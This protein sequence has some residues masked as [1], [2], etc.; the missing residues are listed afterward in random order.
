[1]AMKKQRTLQ[2]EL[3]FKGIGVHSGVLSSIRLLPADKDT[4]II[5]YN[6][7]FPDEPIKIGTL[8]PEKVMY[9]TVIKQRNWMISTVEHLMAALYV[10]GIDNVAIHVNGVEI[11]ILDGSALPFLQGILACGIYEQDA[12]KRFI[13]PRKPITFSTDDGR[14][15]EIAEAQEN[16]YS[17]K[18]EYDID[19]E[20][21]LIHANR[22]SGIISIDFFKQEIAPA[23]TFG[24]IEQLPFLKERG[25]A[26]GTS[27]GNTVVIGKEDYLNERRFD[28]EHIRHKYL[29]LIGD[30]AIIGLPLIGHIKA[31]KTGHI[32]NRLVVEHV[33]SHPNQWHIRF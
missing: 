24:F 19:F 6:E 15:L 9:A 31:K 27:L 20:H 22:L 23:R 18:I 33:L 26:R 5:F 21:Y 16:N 14:Y 10:V 2:K 12:K 7:R 25:L 29:D 11:P 8:V 17:L 28:D 1:M 3:I 32:F 4:G 30:L 13:S